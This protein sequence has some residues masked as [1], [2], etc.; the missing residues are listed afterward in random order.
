MAA[1]VAILNIIIF[2]F[3]HICIECVT[4]LHLSTKFHINISSSLIVTA[5]YTIFIILPAAILDFASLHHKA[6]MPS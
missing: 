1:M 4:N 6:T 2:Y 5:R 3:L